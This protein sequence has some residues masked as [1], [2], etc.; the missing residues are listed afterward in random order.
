MRIFFEELEL[1]KGFAKKIHFSFPFPEVMDENQDVLDFSSVEFTGE[2]KYAAGLVEVEGTL[3]YEAK[4]ACGRCLNHFQETYNVPFKE[5][6]LRENE[7]VYKE[8][9]EDEIHRIQEESFDLTPYCKEE[10]FLA[11]PYIPI[12]NQECKGLCPHCGSNRNERECGCNIER[13]D[14]RLADLA[15]L[16]NQDQG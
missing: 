16:F 14:P 6:F 10:I 13:I 7:T 8:E 12:C 5:R 1:L 2:A 4:F 11:L 3:Q 9:D 15:K